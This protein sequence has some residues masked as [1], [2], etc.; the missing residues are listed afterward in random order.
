MLGLHLEEDDP[1][2]SASRQE[3]T[4]LLNLRRICP[5]VAGIIQAFMDR[6]P[7]YVSKRETRPP[8]GAQEGRPL[9]WTPDLQILKIGRRFP[10][11]SGARRG[12]S[13]D[14]AALLDIPYTLILVVLVVLDVIFC[15]R[16]PIRRTG[17][18]DAGPPL[19]PDPHLRAIPRGK[20]SV[21]MGGLPDA[22]VAG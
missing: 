20:I 4:P 3:H 8:Q 9:D 17:R 14:L 5:Q 22:V 16:D 7:E 10:M 13:A 11:T 12:S 6:G 19:A 21:R 15:L 1:R 18:P 2:A